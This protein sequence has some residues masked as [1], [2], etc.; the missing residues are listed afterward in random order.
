MVCSLDGWKPSSDASSYVFLM[1]VLVFQVH[2]HVAHVSYY[3]WVKVT[4]CRPC[5]RATQLCRAA[6]AVEPPASL[7][8]FMSST[9]AA[10]TLRNWERHLRWDCCKG[11]HSSWRP[12][13]AHTFSVDVLETNIRATSIL[14]V[15]TFTQSNS[16][17]KIARTELISYSIFL[18]HGT[19]CFLW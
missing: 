4:L 7:R 9:C 15:I 18:L 13:A 14:S 10:A 3:L 12:P 16:K 2:C 1:C 11:E 17:F 5:W 19:R 6:R 8:K